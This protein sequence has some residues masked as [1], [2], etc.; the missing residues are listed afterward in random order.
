MVGHVYRGD[1]MIPKIV[2]DSMYQDATPRRS[3][4]TRT[5]DDVSTR[6]PS[7][8]QRPDSPTIRISQQYPYDHTADIGMVT[9]YRQEDNQTI[10]SLQSHRSEGTPDVRMTHLHDSDDR[11]D[12]RQPQPYHKP[13]RRAIVTHV[14]ITHARDLADADFKVRKSAAVVSCSGQKLDPVREIVF[15]EWTPL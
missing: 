9:P 6:L 10:H 5:D 2:Q 13:L 15:I 4:P 14:P 7:H 11:S 12:T 1:E 8:N 3:D